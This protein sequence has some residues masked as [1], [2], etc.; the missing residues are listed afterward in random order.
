MNVQ[1]VFKAS[2]LIAALIAVF[3]ANDV[4][5]AAPAK[6]GQ[7]VVGVKVKVVEEGTGAV[8][9]RYGKVNVHYTGWLMDGTKFDS[10]RDRGEPLSFVLGKGRVIPGWEMGIEGMKV[11][12]KREL[13]IP[14]ELA[15]GKRGAGSVIPAN[16]TLKFEVELVGLTPPKFVNASNDEL[17]ALMARGVQLIDIRRPEEWKQTGIIEGAHQIT[18]FDK[19]GRFKKDFIGKFGKVVKTQGQEVALICR[20]GSRTSYLSDALS[21]QMGYTKVHNVTRGITQWIADKN[22]VV[23]P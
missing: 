19:G 14:P 5:A 12:G 13:V 23:K 20:T 9:G 6:A 1:K 4:A 16:A 21:S 10:S 18:A 2:V 7:K 22:P 8:A 17:K 11:G 15:Y 3:P